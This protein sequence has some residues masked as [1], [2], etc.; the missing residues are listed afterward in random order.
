MTELCTIK[1]EDCIVDSS[2]SVREDVTESPN[3]IDQDELTDENRRNTIQLILHRNF[4]LSGS[5]RR[6]ASQMWRKP[7]KIS[8]PVIIFRF[9]C[10][11]EVVLTVSYSIPLFSSAAVRYAKFRSNWRFKPGD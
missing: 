2:R 7:V 3:V 1:E 10:W 8:P 11:R 6:D 9:G 4:K 5:I